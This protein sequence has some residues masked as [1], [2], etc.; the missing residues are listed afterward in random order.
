MTTTYDM[1]RTRPAT[2]AEE[3]SVVHIE[4]I[5]RHRKAG[6]TGVIIAADASE[7][8]VRMYSAR[9]VHGRYTVRTADVTG[10]YPG[11]VR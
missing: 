11:V 2:P 1:D 5:T 3:Q 9:C 4:T 8:T 6:I 10:V 7:I